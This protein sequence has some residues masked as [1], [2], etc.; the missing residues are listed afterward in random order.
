MHRYHTLNKFSSAMGGMLQ[1]RGWVLAAEE[2]RV[3]VTPPIVQ[4]LWSPFFV[5]CCV[6]C[7]V[8][9]VLCC[10][11]LFCLPAFLYFLVFCLCFQVMAAVQAAHAA[12]GAPPAFIQPVAGARPT[13]PTYFRTNKFTGVFQQV[14]DTYG[15]PRYREANPALFTAAT[16]PFLFAIM[17]GDVGHALL[18]FMFSA[19]LIVWEKPLQERKLN[20]L[21]SMAFGGRY[22]LSCCRPR[23]GVVCGRVRGIVSRHAYEARATGTCCS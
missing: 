17:Y 4:R 14:V 10:F 23:R 16:F 8:C 13:P 9:F 20:E 18:L 2:D 3:R 1:G 15:V 6:F 21:V 19:A 5:L 22:A 11:V 12:A 7:V